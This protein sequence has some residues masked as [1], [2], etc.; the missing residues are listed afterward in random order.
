MYFFRCIRCILAS[1]IAVY[2]VPTPDLKPA[3]SHDTPGSRDQLCSEG[4]TMRVSG[5]AL[6]MTLDLT[7]LPQQVREKARQVARLPY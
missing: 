3:L 2:R 1:C 4:A 5:A 7:G 6:Q